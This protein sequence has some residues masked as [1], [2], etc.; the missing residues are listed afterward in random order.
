MDEEEVT[1]MLYIYQDAKS[2]LLAVGGE[3]GSVTLI[4]L[5]KFRI[6]FKEQD[7]IKSELCWIGMSSN[8]L[9]TCNCDQNLVFYNIQ[10]SKWLD[11]INS[12]CLYLDEVIDIKIFKP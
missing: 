4:D 6:V 12:K 5:A 8:Q 2:S 3:K 10:D 9:V 7:F 11:K 1:C